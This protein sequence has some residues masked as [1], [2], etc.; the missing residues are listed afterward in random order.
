MHQ[1]VMDY[2]TQWA[3][4]L[5][6]NQ[7]G[8]RVLEVGSYDVNGSVRPLFNQTDYTGIDVEEG[9][10]VD[11]VLSS[12][13]LAV[14]YEPNVFDAVACCEMLEHDLNPWHTVAM[15]RYVLNVGG[16]VIATA[17]GN[18]FGHHN[19]P[20]RFRFMEDGWRDMWADHFE[21]VDMRA[22]PQ[23]QGWFIVAR[24]LTNAWE[25]VHQL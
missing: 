25:D 14:Q 21:I 12:H 18:G 11:L 7:P 5:S 3:G 23:V 2:V 15:I 19:P 20:D 13:K 10:G 16:Y 4:Q 8:M 22:D 24:K 17:R 6:L 1:S 9:P